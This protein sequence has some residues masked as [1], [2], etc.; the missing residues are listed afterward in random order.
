M[1]CF[2]LE[3]FFEHS[4][5]GMAT[6]YVLQDRDDE[7]SGNNNQGH[8]GVGLGI[9][10]NDSN[11]PNL[12]TNQPAVTEVHSTTTTVK[13]HKSTTSVSRSV[14]VFTELRRSQSTGTT[15]P[16]SIAKPKTTSKTAGN[17]H[18][19]ELVLLIVTG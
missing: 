15:P 10:K 19:K 3:L 4:I 16:G 13:S 9:G 2:N 14:H 5:A 6:I 8:S 18:S 12:T 17:F 7:S 11:P 1:N